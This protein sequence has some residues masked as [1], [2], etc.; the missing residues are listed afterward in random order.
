MGAGKRA[1]WVTGTVSH[2]ARKIRRFDKDSPGRTKIL[3]RTLR[4]PV[5]DAARYIL[6]DEAIAKFYDLMHAVVLLA[7]HAQRGAES[8]QAFAGA[9]KDFRDF[10]S[11]YRGDDNISDL[12]LARIFA[13]QAGLD[14]TLLVR[15]GANNFLKAF[16]EV[17]NV[18]KVELAAPPK[19]LRL[20]KKEPERKKKNKI[21]PGM[22]K[23]RL[24][25][26]DIV[27][28]AWAERAATGRTPTGRDRTLIVHGPLAYTGLTWHAVHDSVARRL[29]GLI[30]EMKARKTMGEI[31]RE[32]GIPKGKVVL[33]PLDLIWTAWAVYRATGKPLVGTKR[34][35]FLVKA[36]RELPG[37]QKTDVYRELFGKNIITKQM[38][39][40]SAQAEWKA[41]GRIPTTRSTYPIVHGPLAHTGLSWNA[42]KIAG[43]KGLNGMKKGQK[44]GPIFVE[45]GL[46]V[47]CF[48]GTLT[49]VDIVASMKEET[50]TTGR[51]PV[52]SDTR[53]I[54]HGPLAH[55]GLNWNTVKAACAREFHGFSGKRTFRELLEIA[56]LERKQRSQKNSTKNNGLSPEI[57]AP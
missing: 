39:M 4:N 17:A 45:A 21:V 20:K 52:G 28:S 38:I 34:N 37:F 47:H 44:L 53:P 19:P 57:A 30:Y 16:Q 25:V 43:I 55:T 27:A 48:S 40:D 22:F 49:V 36:L 8:R 51:I 23:E 56:G 9:V 46:P 2:S 24:T 5:S 26:A 50:Q 1:T 11:D 42:V 12:D 13:S 7:E 14:L 29:H 32:A 33:T 41:T 15:G 10:I 31:F 54:V 35:S 3:E 6:D 18:S